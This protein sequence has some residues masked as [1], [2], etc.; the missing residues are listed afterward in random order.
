[1]DNINVKAAS[2][3]YVELAEQVAEE[4]INNFN[5]SEQREVM[6]IIEDRI[7]SNYSSRVLEAEGDLKT[8]KSLQSQ[9]VDGPIAEKMSDPMS[10]SLSYI[11]N[12]QR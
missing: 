8:I 5:P 9:F 7:K 1:M 11:G 12:D 6:Y 2:P 10:G 3:R 4:M